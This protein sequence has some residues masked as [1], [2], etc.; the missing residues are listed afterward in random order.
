MCKRYITEKGSPWVRSWIHPLYR[1]VIIICDL[2]PVEAFSVFARLHRELL[3]NQVQRTRLQNIFALH[4]EREYLVIPVDGLI[5]AQAQ[6]LVMRH[7][8]RTLDAIQLACAQQA[9]NVLGEPIMFVS[10][11]KQLLRAAV[12]EG[13]TTDDPNLHP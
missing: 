12:A 9:A 5:L 1:N 2:A 11:D 10:G 6:Q 7:P 8:L 3:I 13:F 4:T